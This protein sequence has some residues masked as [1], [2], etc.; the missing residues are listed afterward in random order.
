MSALAHPFAFD[1]TYGTTEKD[2]LSVASPDPPRDFESFWKERRRAAEAVD[3]AP[4]TE[5][6]DPAFATPHHRAYRWSY[7]S[8]RDVRIRGWLLVPYPGPAKRGFIVA[9][10]YG[11]R[12]APDR[13]LPFQ[14]AVLAFPCLRGL[15]LSRLPG[16]PADPYG[17]VLHGIERPE[18]YIHGGCVEDIWCGVSALLRLHPEVEGR[19]GFLGISFGAGIGA[20][21][22]AWEPRVSRA[23][24]NVPSFGNHP[25]RLQCPT[26]GSGEAV[27]AYVARGGNPFPAL[28]YHDAASAA[29]FVR[30]PV[31]C[32]LAR[33][34]PAVAPPGQFSVFN[35]LAGERSLTILRA[36]HFPYPEAEQ[37]AARLRIE[38]ERFFALP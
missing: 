13:D 32:A 24:L 1:P 37:E 17:H 10:G 7:R 8:T 9:H 25:L 22:L 30:I 35:A 27:R 33:F 5:P 15:S 12:T 36:G 38:L 20:M 29:R 31:H 34:D 6:A 26:V 16:V 28:A 21:A 14:D 18:T 3:V 11:G 19:I 4:E 23:H 2:L